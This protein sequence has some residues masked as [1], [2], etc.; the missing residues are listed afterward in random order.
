LAA[1]LA[2]SG[3]YPKAS[4]YF[5]HCI[6]LKGD[7]IPAHFGLAKILHHANEDYDQALVHYNYVIQIDEK[8]YKALC[9]I[10]NI[11]LIQQDYG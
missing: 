4:K 7:S 9:Q 10:G 5:N 6:K 8:H 11:Y 1:I 3:N 2:N